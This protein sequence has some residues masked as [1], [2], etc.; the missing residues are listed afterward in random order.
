M[1]LAQR[2]LVKPGTRLDLSRFD[3]KSTAG[4]DGGKKE[5]AE[6]FAE[7]NGQIEELQERLWAEGRQK[8]L[9]VL[10]G[11]DASGKDGTIRSVFE[12]V[13]PLGT[14]VAA[15]G[16]PTEEE[17]AHDFLWRVHSKVPGKGEIAIFNRS[18]YEDVLVVRVRK[19]APKSV[20]QARFRQINDF[21]RLLAETGTKIVKIYLCISK[22]EQ[23]E[24]LQERLDDPAKRWKFRKGDLEDRALWD[25]YQTAY[26]EAISETSQEG[27]PWYVV[28][29]DRNWYRN[30][31][32]AD[33]L[34]AALREMDP[35]TPEPEED[36]A[37][38]VVE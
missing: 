27:A 9:V 3:P 36:L 28:P 13:N 15:F 7:L 21:E 10:Q 1:K 33:I 24:R 2:Y 6:P 19:L 12:G 17:L 8:L 23:K 35:K 30:L 29:A 34:V 31:V 11:L 20:W 18:H 4:F 26:E 38:I 32:V 22:E 14:R 25:D 5:A 37:G 16:V